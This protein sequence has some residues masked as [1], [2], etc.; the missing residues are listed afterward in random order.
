MESRWG[1]KFKD[2]EQ[3]SK[4]LFLNFDMMNGVDSVK[5]ERNRVVA[6]SKKDRRDMDRIANYAIRLILHRTG[7]PDA[8][9]PQRIDAKSTDFIVH[10]PHLLEAV[11]HIWKE[12]GKDN[13]IGKYVSTGYAA[14][15]LY[16]MGSS[17]TDPKAYRN[18]DESG[19][20][21]LDWSQW[22]KACDY[23]TILA[24]D[25][26]E[27]H[28]VRTALNKSTE[29]G[30]KSNAECWAII[31]KAW[32][33]FAANKEITD[34]SLEIEYLTDDDGVRTLAECPTVGG[35]D[36]GKPQEE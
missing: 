24:G 17:A 29:D 35:I 32:L 11:N 4:L 7:N 28:A 36:I 26:Q 31:I 22:N 20:D 18:V 2:D 5:P 34:K 25:A 12:N 13:R 10:H 21:T 15:L 6:V 19:D 14:G 30:V 33:C 1:F 23:F 3:K 8:F 16:L 27:T 9:A